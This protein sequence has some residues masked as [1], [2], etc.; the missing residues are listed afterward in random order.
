MKTRAKIKPVRD[1]KSKIRADNIWKTI[2]EIQIQEGKKGE[3][4]TA[5]G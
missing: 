1:V 4:R 5:S 3:R 2:S